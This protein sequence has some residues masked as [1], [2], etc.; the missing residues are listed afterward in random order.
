MNQIQY[1]RNLKLVKQVY[2]RD[3][4]KR[5]DAMARDE[6]FM[7]ELKDRLGFLV[8]EMSEMMHP[9]FIAT[10]PDFIPPID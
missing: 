7:L 6:K 5:L 2:P 10:H 3:S 9:D 1:K 4:E 8:G